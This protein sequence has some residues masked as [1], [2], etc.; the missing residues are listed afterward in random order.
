M[1]ESTDDLRRL[2]RDLETIANWNDDLRDKVDRARLCFELIGLDPEEQE[3]LEA[4]IRRF[5]QAVAALC[6]DPQLL[7]NRRA[8]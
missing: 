4:E 2:T 7:Q 6:G 8:A 5:K 1:I 3:A